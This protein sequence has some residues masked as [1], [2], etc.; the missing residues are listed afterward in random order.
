VRVALHTWNEK[1]VTDKDVSLAREIE[2]VAR[3]AL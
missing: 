1:A 2:A 3:P